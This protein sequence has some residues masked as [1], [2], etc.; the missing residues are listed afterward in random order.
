MAG[1]H[2]PH[3]PFSLAS[4]SP[5]SLKNRLAALTVGL[6][7][8]F[9]WALVLASAGI[10]ERQFEHVLAEQQL[11]TVR[12]VAAGIDNELHQRIDGLVRIAPGIA[13]L[14]GKGPAAL[15]GYLASQPILGDFF[16]GG[17]AIIG[18]DGRTIA[19]YPAA[20]GRRGTYYGDRDYFRQA[21][22]ARK[23]YVDKPVIGRALKRP[24]LTIGV[25]VLDA[26]GSARAVLT[27][28]SDLTG[29]NLLGIL[30]DR[31]M[32]GSAEFFVISPGENVIIAATDTRHAM[33]PPP[34][35]GLNPAY[36]RLADG[37]EG[38]SIGANSLGVQKLYSGKKIPAANWVVMAGLP[39]SVAF[40]PLRVMQ[41][42]MYLLGALLTVVA[43]FA[44]RRMS[45]RALAPLADASEAMRRM[46][47]RELPLAPL[48][49]GRED[50]I[51]KLIDNFNRL[52]EDRSR[53]E[54]ALAESEQ[55]FRM[56]VESAPEA[57]FVQVRG[58][59]AYVNAATV[60]L[61]GAHDAADL[62][63]QPV[64]D[65]VAPDDR[66]SVS[67][68]IR[69]TNQSGTAA[70]SREE[71]HLRL[72]GTPI[73]LEVSGVP[74]SY[75]DENGAL[76]FARDITDRKQAG[77]ELSKLWLAV[78][79]SPNGVL[80]TDLSARIEYANEAMVQT[81]GYSREELLGQNPRLLRSGRTPRETALSLWAALA[82]GDTWRGEFVNRRKNGE[83]Y[84]EYE[85]I[86][87][88]RQDDGRIT[89]YL[90]VKE[91]ITERKHLAIELDNYREHLEYMVDSRTREIEELNRQL[92][93]RA[94]EAE[95]AT[96]AKSIF[97]A[98]VSHEIRTPI[99]VIMGF[100]NLGLRRTRDPK[101]R[102][103]LSKIS[104]ASRHLLQVINDVLDFSKIEAGK[105]VVTTGPFGLAEVFRN[106]DTL[107]AQRA[108]SK[109]L[110]F[111]RILPSRLAE[112]RLL[113][114]PLRLG[115]ILINYCGNAV[116]FTERGGVTLSAE[117][118]EETASDV[119]ARFEVVDSGIGIAPEDQ[120]RLFTA[121]EQADGS[122]TRKY[123]G[124]GLG[125][126]ISRHL[127]ELMGGRVGV[128]S[129]PG[130]G[131][132]FWLEVRLGKASE[133]AT[134]APPTDQARLDDAEAA[135]R[136]EH[137]GKRVLI[138]EDEALNQQIVQEILSGTGLAVDVAGSGADAVEMVRGKAYDAIL[139]DVQ[140]PVMDGLAAAQAI[141]SLP[142]RAHVPIIA[143]T[144]NAFT[145]DRRRCLD[146]GMDDYIAKPC[147]PEDLFA[148]LLKWLAPRQP[149][150]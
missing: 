43:L 141:R 125:L 76:V 69:D 42:T 54:S 28:I 73:D 107:V 51:G 79:Q 122:T 49:R 71:K 1:S 142:G 60:R 147:Y 108:Q 67:R 32:T 19:D 5:K 8:A 55:R 87:P 27:G 139:M 64:L 91:D 13:P 120:P 94:L 81:S 2:L 61:F 47:H 115:Q 80:I 145:E 17:M 82:K 105:L 36:D 102:E 106:V 114:D 26:N 130:C 39:T 35:R 31:A 70:S 62:L 75:G 89:H 16:S 110:T 59:F 117:I 83:I 92:E 56:L 65:R 135:L 74:V 112:L 18:L 126:A 111:E 9:I 6:V 137:A 50:E 21:I 3:L 53:Y 72:D 98:N 68:R 33:T 95:S 132:R 11:A 109:G 148:M 118:L 88:V 86:S 15:E 134:A 138:A 103:Q 14:L 113:G 127:A 45:Q 30:S 100:T 12:Y 44:T 146:A 22:A 52:V 7:V 144:A 116:Q 10:L 96:R 90:A 133:D 37:F 104:E 4:L 84:Y 78:E 38:S 99:S 128:E 29:P 34:R 58:R 149:P 121:F 41:Q 46:T 85:H 97:L 77:E 66:Q 123:G 131:S 23:P 63:G 48:P 136:S 129:R 101:L 40:K 143:M 124:S 140:M 57:I 119:L 20:P 25:P 93:R 24:V 150:A